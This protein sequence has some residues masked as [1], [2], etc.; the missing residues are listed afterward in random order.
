MIYT[1]YSYKGGV[2]RS[3]AL[4]NIA[5]LLYSKG[6]R[7]LMIDFDLEAPGLEQYFYEK[8]SPLLK[9]VL[10][11]R[12]IIDLLLS[13][14]EL[15]S[16]PLPQDCPEDE[17]E[18][19][20]AY[21]EEESPPTA[22]LPADEAFPYPVEPLDNFIWEIHPRS[23]QNP[24][25]LLLM[26]AGRRVREVSASDGQPAQ[27]KDDF[28][29]YANHVRA[30]G[31]DD[32]YLN[33]DGEQ[34]FNWF[35]E[36][37]NKRA[38]VVLIDS[39]TGVA[40]MSGV[41]TYQLADVVVM[42]V[43]P[44]NQNVDGTNKIAASLVNR[45]DLI[46]KRYQQRKL[47]VI[48]VPSRVDLGERYKVD[49]LAIR[50]RE[51]ASRLASP[52]LTFE[53]DTFNDLTI[54]YIPYYSFVEELVTRDIDSASPVANKM[55]VAYENICRTLAQLDPTIKAKMREEV[56]DPSRVNVA[57]RQD[58][59]AEHAYSKLTPDQQEA[60]RSVFTRLVR[61]AL[62][63]EGERKD[64][65]KDVKLSDLTPEQKSMAKVL[66]KEKLLVLAK[67]AAGQETVG[68]AEEDLI[69]NWKRFKQWI[70][71]DREFLIWRQK[72]QTPISDWERAGRD[73]SY[74]LQSSKYM[75]AVKW[76]NSHQRELNLTESVYILTSLAKRRRERLQSYAQVAG[77]I[78]AVIGL[79]FALYTI[80]QWRSNNSPAKIRSRKLASDSEALIAIQPELSVL[81]AV[82]ALRLAPTTEANRAL[83]N[84]LQQSRLR[85]VIRVGA[86]VYSAR[87]SHDGTRIVTGSGDGGASVAQIWQQ[88]EGNNWQNPI[89][90]RGHQERVSAAAFSPS[91]QL[92]ATA[93]YDGNV[94][95]WNAANGKMT[96]PPQRPD[97]RSL[98]DID[99][100]PDEKLVAAANIADNSVYVWEVET[101]KLSEALRGFTDNV[102]SVSFS[103]DGKYLAAGSRDKT[104]RIWDTKTWEEARPPLTIHSGEVW[105]VRFSQNG[106]FLVTA[107]ADNTARVWETSD[108]QNVVALSG[109]SNSIK[110]ASFSPD[111]RL[112]VTASEDGT[113]MV[114]ETLTG[115]RVAVLRGSLGFVN[116]AS[117]SPDGKLVLTASMDG[118]ARLW[119]LNVEINPNISDTELI[120]LACSRV[121]RNM[122]EEEWRQY[123]GTDAYKLTC[124]DILPLQ[125]AQTPA[126]AASPTLQPS[127]SPRQGAAGTSQKTS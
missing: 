34:F 123:M 125:P 108:W 12:G 115:K 110:R 68:L 119:E 40:E 109:H 44:N 78:L 87:Y 66:E 89:I 10:S 43:A 30:F 98:A 29:S 73:K 80:R 39:R 27:F 83:K 13:Y 82:E 76:L 23:S 114:W 33:W 58:R 51:V 60:A 85:T 75:E 104:V 118:T 49:D 6:L 47:S 62:P 70:D 69:Q 14:K 3:M 64:T 116:D 25:E 127:T 126:P 79:I 5:E 65:P 111:G 107:G 105:S 2:G 35:Y 50:F 15:R 55:K 22:D 46:K 38:Q 67:D 106:K 53:T 20:T 97:F 99:W 88:G 72:L 96:R 8:D 45:E 7:V 41:C 17:A 86:P 21:E 48:F 56:D 4:A 74:L 61:L 42:F 124:S 77:L 28:A 112:V 26:T 94:I 100:N 9:Q 54:P 52:D 93:S 24:G 92:I 90:L 71:E 19:V 122:T 57:E 103:P 113:A 81:L 95:F 102:N 1:C 63:E 84:A 91:D 117:F 37:A 36:K 101:P 59:L 32:F 18:G 16:L 120:S 31:W 121:T 11:Q